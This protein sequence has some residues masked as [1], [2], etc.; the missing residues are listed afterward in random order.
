MLISLSV[1]TI[2]MRGRIA[3]YMY[4]HVLYVCVGP[5]PRGRTLPQEMM[6]MMNVKLPIPDVAIANVFIFA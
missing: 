6:V 4:L 3:I 5:P 2:V 1:A